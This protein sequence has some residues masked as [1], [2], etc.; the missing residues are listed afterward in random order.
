MFQHADGY[1]IARVAVA[2]R[3][4]QKYARTKGE[5]QQAQQAANR[6]AAHLHPRRGH[7]L[8]L[9]QFDGPGGAAPAVVG[10]HGAHQAAQRLRPRGG[11]RAGAVA[12]ALVPPV[13]FTRGQGAMADAQGGLRA[14]PTTA[15]TVPALLPGAAQA[16]TIC[17]RTRSATDRHGRS[18]CR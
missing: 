11:H 15:A 17:Y 18:R 7:E 10:R 16:T 12:L 9:Q 2:G 4:V 3:R 5:A 8:A 13:G 6:G 14:Q 1:W